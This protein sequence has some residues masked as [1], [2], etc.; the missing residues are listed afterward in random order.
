MEEEG[1][2]DSVLVL[3]TAQ[4]T[5]P[6]VQVWTTKTGRFGSRPDQITRSADTCQAKPG[7]IFINPRRLPG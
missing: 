1:L 5:P 2:E 4:G 7:Y 3:V 6:A